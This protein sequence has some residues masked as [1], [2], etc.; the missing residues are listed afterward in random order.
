MLVADSTTTKV[1]RNHSTMIMITDLMLASLVLH[2]D[3]NSRGHVSYTDG[4][5]G[6]ID[7]LSRISVARKA[8]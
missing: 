6:F 7:M 4:R 3:A 2:G 5:F 8:C 1:N